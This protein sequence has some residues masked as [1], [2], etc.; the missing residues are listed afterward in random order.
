L[1]SQPSTSFLLV[2]APSRDTAPDALHFVRTVQEHQFHFEGMVVNRCLSHLGPVQKTSGQDRPS[3]L[4]AH[5][6]T[7]LE[8]IAGLQE[9]EKAALE[10]LH[11]QLKNLSTEGPGRSPLCLTLPELARDVHSL[12]DL[13]EISRALEK[14]NPA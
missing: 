12:S 4:S 9:R 8:V 13:V 1:L 10:D 14:F 3:A 11:L 2:A 6:K 7:A 5:Q